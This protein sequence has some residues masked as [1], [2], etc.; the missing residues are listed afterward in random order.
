MTSQSNRG[1]VAAMVAGAGLGPQAGAAL[2]ANLD[3]TILMGCVGAPVDDLDAKG[4]TIAG[5]KVGVAKKTSDGYAVTPANK[6]TAA[7]YTY[8]PWVLLDEGG[9]YNHWTTWNRFSEALRYRDPGLTPARE[10]VIARCNGTARPMRPAGGA[11]GGLPTTT[12]VL[13]YLREHAACTGTK[14]GCAEGDCGACTV[15]QGE[16]DAAGRLQRV[17]RASSTT[18]VCVRLLPSI[19]TQPQRQTRRL[20]RRL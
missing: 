5:W 7:L 10:I 3:E 20:I 11:G 9:N 8:T 4:T 19:P 6:A 1:K 16:L 15:I 14:E 12:T 17:L 13:Q 18:P 2:V